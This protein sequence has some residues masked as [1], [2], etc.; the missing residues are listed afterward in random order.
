MSGYGDLSKEQIEQLSAVF[1]SEGIEHVKGLAESLFALEEERGDPAEL[2]AR[3]FRE[4]HS[5]KGAAGNVAAPAF[6]ETA[7]AMEQAGKAGDVESMRG[8]LPE[9]EQR[10]L[11][12]KM[13][14]ESEETCE[15]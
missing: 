7:H 12:L 3:A 13:R 15:F 14:M 8:L 10:F 5:L 2:L 9:L 6:Q 1:R 4:A 11:Q